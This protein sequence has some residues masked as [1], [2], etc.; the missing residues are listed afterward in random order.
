MQL[1]KLT[2]KHLNCHWNIQSD[3]Y[4]KNQTRPKHYGAQQPPPNVQVKQTSP[5]NL[6]TLLVVLLMMRVHARMF[7]NQS[8]LLALRELPLLALCWLSWPHE[9]SRAGRPSTSTKFMHA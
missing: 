1:F 8:L 9:T 7:P 6:G 5:L 2:S 4:L 3:S